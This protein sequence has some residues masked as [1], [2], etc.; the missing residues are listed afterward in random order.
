MA[1][2]L[3]LPPSLILPPTGRLPHGGRHLRIG[4]PPPRTVFLLPSQRRH[5]LQLWTS[6]E[7]CL[8]VSD[9]ASTGAYRLSGMEDLGSPGST[10][11][12]SR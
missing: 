12:L 8:I 2:R 1:G 3:P 7:S 9:L 11:A 10:W 6:M 4:S 5:L